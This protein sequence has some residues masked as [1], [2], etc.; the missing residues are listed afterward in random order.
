MLKLTDLFEDKFIRDYE[1]VYGPM[2]FKRLLDKR[3]ECIRGIIAGEVKP[4]AIIEGLVTV[5]EGA[6]IEPGAYVRGPA[7][8]GRG[9]VIR[10]GAYIRGNVYVSANCVV[11]HATELKNAIMLEGAKVPHF[12]YVGDSIVGARVNIGVGAKITN[13]KIT[14]TPIL[15]LGGQYKK[16]GALIGDD[17]QIGANSIINPG[18]IIHK[19]S[20]VYPLVSV[21]GTIYKDKQKSFDTID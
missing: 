1:V 17:S 20:L 5:E 2:D 11:G 12:S 7:F 16:F 14:K 8:I 18:A 3:L 10:H 15:V 21:I 19:G 6:I 4:G 9:S 13:T